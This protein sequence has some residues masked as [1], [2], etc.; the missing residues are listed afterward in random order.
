MSNP[1]ID[2]IAQSI[3]EKDK[4][5][6]LDI[7]KNLDSDTLK[8]RIGSVDLQQA[9]KAMR[10]MNLSE[11]ADKLEGMTNDDLLNR[12]SQNPKIIESLK[13]IFN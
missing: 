4:K 1:H 10:Q 12:I 9:A 5:E 8:E 7:L 3:S 11:A 2:K 6:T 13:K